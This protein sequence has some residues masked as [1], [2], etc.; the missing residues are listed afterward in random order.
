[1]TVFG[2]YVQPGGTV[3]DRLLVDAAAKGHTFVNGFILVA[4]SQRVDED[5]TEQVE[6]VRP[7]QAH[8]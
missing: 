6:H 5:G 3:R 4:V 2:L 8:G 7:L 1:M